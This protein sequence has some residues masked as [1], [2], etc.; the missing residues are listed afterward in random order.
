[1]R[2]DERGLYSN[3]LCL[4][5][6]VDGLGLERAVV[7]PGILVVGTDHVVQ[8]ETCSALSDFAGIYT[9]I[10][11]YSRTE[12]WEHVLMGREDVKGES[13][14]SEHKVGREA[15]TTSVS[16]QQAVDRQ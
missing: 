13:Y 2:K 8:H 15:R 16:L 4:G 6:T 7:Y 14:E 3:R 9:F 11:L 10:M 12:V 5:W 1:M